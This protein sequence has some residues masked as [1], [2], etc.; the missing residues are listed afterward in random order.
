MASL[1]TPRLYATSSAQA[2][3]ILGGEHSVVYGGPALVAGIPRGL[4][5]QAE[6]LPDPQAPID[7]QIPDWE[8]SLRLDPE[9]QNPVSRAVLEVLGHCD[10]PLRGFRISGQSTIPARAG[11]GSSAALSVAI[12]RLALGPN[13]SLETLRQAS[14]AGE[15]IFHGSPSGIDTECSLRGG[16]WRFVRGQEPQPIR[17]DCALALGIVPT[18]IPR[19]TSQLVALVKQKWERLPG[20]QRPLL[21]AIDACVEEMQAA[22]Q[23]DDR[24]RLGELMNVNHELLSALGVSSPALDAICNHARSLGAWGAKLTGAG[25]GGSIVLLAPEPQLRD[26]IFLREVHEISQRLGEDAPP[27]FCVH[28]EA[29]LD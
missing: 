10:A 8:L 24:P 15:G 16:L 12:A 4:Q 6:A 27:P 9:E 29:S 22:L 11:L 23:S 7:L 2:K 5:L 28:L 20:L 26:P 1:P 17:R 25:R 21:A 19:Q 14:L 3:V 18:G 13:A